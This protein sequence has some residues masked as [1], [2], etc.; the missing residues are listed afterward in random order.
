M[1]AIIIDDEK[2]ARENLI[3]MIEQHCTNLNVV[4]EAG[5]EKGIKDLIFLRSLK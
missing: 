1:T 2:K 3:F 5:D 4:G